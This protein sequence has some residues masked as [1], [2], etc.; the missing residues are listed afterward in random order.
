MINNYS[1]YSETQYTARPTLLKLQALT[2]TNWYDW[3][4]S[5]QTTNYY[6]KSLM[7]QYHSTQQLSDLSM[8]Q[9]NSNSECTNQM[10]LSVKPKLS[11]NKLNHNVNKQK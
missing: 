6:L 4:I 2:S 8:K 1:D 7:N 9:W 11:Y 5:T 10:K 3:P